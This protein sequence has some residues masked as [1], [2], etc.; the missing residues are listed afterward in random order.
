MQTWQ[1]SQFQ[2]C[3][4]VHARHDYESMFCKLSGRRAVK[5]VGILYSETILKSIR[6]HL[7]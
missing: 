4:G 3:D 5:Y 7:Q 1:H 6:D 2:A